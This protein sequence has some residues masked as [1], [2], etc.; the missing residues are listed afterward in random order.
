MPENLILLHAY[1]KAA[2]QPA[3]MRSLVSAFVIRSLESRIPKLATG[4]ISLF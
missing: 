1:N 4:K 3:Q 2:D